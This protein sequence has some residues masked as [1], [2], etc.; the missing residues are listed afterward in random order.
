MSLSH[1][2]RRAAKLAIDNSPTILT[3]IGVVGTVTTAYLAGK[4]S[5]EAADI[6]RLK[7][8]DDDERGISAGTP[9]EV[10]KS[11]VQLVWQLYI[12]AGLT[13]AAT[14]ACIIGANTIGTRRAA[15]LAAAYTLT[16]KSL[17]E[18]RAKVVEK[19]GE[20]KEEAIRDEIVQDRITATWDDS[21]D[22]HGKVDGDVFY[23]KYSDRYVWSTQEALR[24]AVNDLNQ[25]ILHQG[26]ATAAD[27]YYLIGMPSPSW[28]T[29]VGWNS[30]GKLMEPRFSSHLTPGGKPVNAFEFSVEPVRSYMRFH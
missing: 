27:F 13:S 24:S 22:I 12:P 16:E 2:A 15:G 18:Y 14:I 10:L 23:D 20:R 17:D 6:I 8:A 19:I 26:Y 21:I 5:F 28:S 4:A 1:L 3:T 9:Q 29:E 30:D 25:S 7:E 11:R